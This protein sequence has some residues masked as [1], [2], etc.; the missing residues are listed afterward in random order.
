MNRNIFTQEDA[1]RAARFAEASTAE[2]IQDNRIGIAMHDDAG[3]TVRYFYTTSS[4]TSQRLP[5][6]ISSRTD[7]AESVDESA[8]QI[9]YALLSTTGITQ[10][11]ALERNRLILEINPMYFWDQVQD[12]VLRV[13]MR[14]L[15]WLPEDTSIVSFAD[16]QRLAKQR[17]TAT[18]PASRLTQV[19]EHR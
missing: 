19:A 7:L 13:L 10:I 17:D 6:G 5:G 2:P 4:L 9:V 12:Q 14:G 3:R 1:E 8:R 11:V 16:F 18:L 15:D